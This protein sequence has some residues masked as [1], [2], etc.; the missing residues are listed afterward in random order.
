M[1][2]VPLKYFLQSAKDK[3]YAADGRPCVVASNHDDVVDLVRAIVDDLSA[4]DAGDV[5]I[6][7]PT[8]EQ[9]LDL[10]ERARP[11]MEF[12]VRTDAEPA[13]SGVRT[14]HCLG[15]GQWS[16]APEIE[17][18][19]MIVDLEADD[20][21][22]RW[23]AMS[24]FLALREVNS[25]IVMFGFVDKEILCSE[26]DLFTTCVAKLPP[27]LATSKPKNSFLGGTSAST[28]GKW[29]D[30]D[31]VLYAVHVKRGADHDAPQSMRVDYRVKGGG[32]VSEWVCVEHSGFARRRAEEWWAERAEEAWQVPTSAGEAVRIAIGGAL[33]TPKAIRVVVEGDYEC[34]AECRWDDDASP[35]PAVAPA[36]RT[37]ADDDDI[38]F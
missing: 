9:A 36:W 4:D 17:A 35:E 37:F 31:V 12:Q 11:P 30:V 23:E 34:V 28:G 2:T 16:S 14:I 21:D 26:D 20:Y 32:K 8:V 10:A 15:P 29:L 22:A 38:P 1:R 3:L 19:L 6:F 7:G 27:K 25:S 13:R 5:V 33:R 24:T 18:A